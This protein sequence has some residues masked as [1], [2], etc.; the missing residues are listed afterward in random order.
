MGDYFCDDAI[1]IFY[2]EILTPRHVY[3]NEVGSNIHV[4]CPSQR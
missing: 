4:W 2:I 3:F 1:G